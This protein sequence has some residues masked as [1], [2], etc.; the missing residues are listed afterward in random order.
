MDCP[1]KNGHC[2]EVAISESSTVLFRVTRE[3]NLASRMTRVGSV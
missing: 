3:R 1:P 2:G